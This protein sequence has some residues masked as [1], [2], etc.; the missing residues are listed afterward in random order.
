MTRSYPRAQRIRCDSA[1]RETNYLR[2]SSVNP[3]MTANDG[4]RRAGV[5]CCSYSLTF[6]TV[7]IQTAGADGGTCRR[8]NWTTP[9]LKASLRSPATIWP[10]FGTLKTSSEGR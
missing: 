7:S 9:S 1:A 3:G 5:H 8:R 10:A 6:A 2:K 4:E